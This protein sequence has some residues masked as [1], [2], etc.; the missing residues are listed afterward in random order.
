[1]SY[2]SIILSFLKRLIRAQVKNPVVFK[3]PIAGV[4]FRNFVLPKGEK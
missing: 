3:K 4:L 1:M 2:M